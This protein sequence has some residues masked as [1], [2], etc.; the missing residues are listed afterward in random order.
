MKV[1]ILGTGAYGLA[2]SK[3]LVQNKNEVTLWTTFEEEKNE[4]VSNSPNLNEYVKPEATHIFKEEPNSLERDTLVSTEKLPYLEYIGQALG[5]YLIFQNSEGLYLVDQHA[6]AERINYEKYY[7]ILGNPESIT[8][9]L[10]V[11]ISLS[12]TK[13]EMLFIEE[14]LKEFEKLGFS[15]EPISNQDYIIR[16]IPLWANLAEVEEIV[17]EA[18]A[19][20][21]DSKKVSIIDFRDHMAKQISCKASIKANHALNNDEIKTLMAN[22]NKCNNPFT[23]PH[24]RPTLIKLTISALEKMFERIQS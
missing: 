10:L 20:M 17:R 1:T 2:L 15:L 12:F 22:L 18:F 16:S 8:Q 4:Y 24:G 13:S 3:I 6:A 5:T 11:P 21:L 7:E 14:H 19:L 23:C 9:D